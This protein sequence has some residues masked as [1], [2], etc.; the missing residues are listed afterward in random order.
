MSICL[1]C[2]DKRFARMLELELMD[3]RL[4][5]KIIGEKLSPQAL[6][7]ALKGADVILFD[8]DYYEG[9]LSFI[10]SSPVD[11]IL[12][13]R[14]RPDRLPERVTDF[15]ERPFSV[16]EV[17]DL[18]AYKAGAVLPV[19]A[20]RN[21]TTLTFELDPFTKQV[22]VNG[23]TA[24]LTPREYTLFS[25]LY[26]N[27][28]RIVSRREVLDTVWSDERDIKGYVDSVYMNYLRNKLD[29]PLGIKLI[30]TVRGKGYMMK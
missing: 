5:L 4:Q 6:T 28:G 15:Y 9:D 3:R 23:Y 12:F 14:T 19:T 29:F 16:A 24:R 7:V 11:V 27:R 2:T 8:S 26:Q 10:E 22:T 20:D 25:L 21:G 17:A 13:G 18:A 30:C 1:I